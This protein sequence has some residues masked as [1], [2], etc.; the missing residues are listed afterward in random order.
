MTMRNLQKI[1][2]NGEELEFSIGDIVYY[3]TDEE[4]IPYMVIG[5]GVYTDSVLVLIR[6]QND[7]IHSVYEFEIS[8]DK[9]FH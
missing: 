8:L 9:T 6:N 4:H 5:Y 1:V 3:K 2:L 7:E